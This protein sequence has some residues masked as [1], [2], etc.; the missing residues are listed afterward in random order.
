MLHRPVLCPNHEFLAV[1]EHTQDL[2]IFNLKL[3]RPVLKIQFAKNVKSFLSTISLLKW[4]PESFVGE[5][6]QH[7]Q[8]DIL[9][10]W[11]LLAGGSRLIAVEAGI[12]HNLASTT[13]A[14]ISRADVLVDYQF[15]TQYG[16]IVNADFVLNHNQALVT[17]DMSTHASIVSLTKPQREDIPSPKFA[18]NQGLAQSQQQRHFA[19]LLRPK[20]R[21]QVA[22]FT[23]RDGVIEQPHSF[24]PDTLDAQGLQWSPDGSPVLA[25]WDSMAHG[26]R[27]TFHTA[28]GHALPPLSLLTRDTPSNM[29][30]QDALGIGVTCFRWN[31]SEVYGTILAAGIGGPQLVLCGYDVPSMVSK[32]LAAHHFLTLR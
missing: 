2:A 8:S 4:A 21:D 9:T 32:I 3:G 25:V 16:K 15:E 6:Q 12:P 18:T 27:V 29:P 1:I 7:P 23:S 30:S 19:L 17:F 24:F 31:T 10:T 28:L 11:L 13:P 5:D 22:V 14:T 20:A 26:A